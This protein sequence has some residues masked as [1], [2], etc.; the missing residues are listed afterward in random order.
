[1]LAFCF[2]ITK[3]FQN[4]VF[5]F[6]RVCVCVCVKQSRLRCFMLFSPSNC[7]QVSS[8]GFLSCLIALHCG[9]HTSTTSFDLY[10]STMRDTELCTALTL[11][12]NKTGNMESLATGKCLSAL[13]RLIVT[14]HLLTLSISLTCRPAAYLF[15][16]AAHKILKSYCTL[17]LE[18]LVQWKK[19]Q[20]V[21]L[22]SLQQLFV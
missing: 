7:L 6:V 21:S 19:G 15:V 1:M 22:S 2:R 20:I 14:W 8:P 5:V 16:F 3:R 12:G 10:I 9:T 18:R 17:L 4:F 13:A 11:K